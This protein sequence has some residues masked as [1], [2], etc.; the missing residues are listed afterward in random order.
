[1]SDTK[2]LD[3]LK[4]ILG[5]YY[6]SG[7][8]KLFFCPKCKHHKKKLSVNLDKDAFKCWIC[9][10]SGKSVRRLVL[11]YGN[12][13]QQKTW[14]ELSGIVEITEYEKIFLAEGNV[15]EKIEPISLPPEFQT[16]CNRDLGL[17]SL[18]ARRYLKD[19][20]VTRE[21]I[22]F[23]KIGYAVSGEYAGRI[24]V[25]SFNIDGKVDYFIGRTYE[26][27]WK[28]YLNPPTP[29]DII[30][31]ELYV[32]WSSD[33]TIVEGVFDA[34][35]AKNAIPILGST[36]REGSRL[37]RELIRNDPRI[38]IALDPDAEKKAD[39]LINTLLTYDA[40]VYKIDIPEGKDVGDMSHEEFLER[41]KAAVPM[42]NS[43]YMLLRKIMSL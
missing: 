36:L 4:Q 9:D 10:F 31:N 41:K 42:K 12:Y 32:D 33:I 30:F 14:N 23:W 39:K 28:R 7:H 40:E 20:G 22:L 26:N 16:L 18:P 3:I 6:T 17:S 2:K 29:K 13:V 43:D 5:D 21:D 27:D 24:I 19:R 35:K 25:P 11:R 15:E 38:F 1:M 34:I 8:E 37:F